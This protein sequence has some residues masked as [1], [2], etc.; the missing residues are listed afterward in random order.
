MKDEKAVAPEQSGKPKRRARWTRVKGETG[1]YKREDG[2]YYI[3]FCYNNAWC[4]EAAGKDLSTARALL[5]HKRN[6]ALLDKHG[7]KDNNYSVKKLYK[8]YLAYCEQHLKANTVQCY[9][10]SMDTVWKTLKC[11]RVS[12]IRPEFV[13]EYIKHRRGTDGVADATVRREVLLLKAML[14]FGERQGII[15]YNP[16]KGL[17][18]V[19]I[20]RRAPKHILTMEEFDR[21]V[22]HVHPNGSRAGRCSSNR[23]CRNSDIWLMLGL[24]GLRKSELANLRWS[25]VD[26]DRAEINI[27]EHEDDEGPKTAASNRTIPVVERVRLMLLRRSA[28]GTDGRV[29]TT[30]SGGSVA[31]NLLGKLHRCLDAAGID[32]TGISL[33]ALRRTFCS[34]LISRGAP[35]KAVQELMGHKD[36]RITLGVYAKTLDGD[37][38]RAVDVLDQRQSPQA[39][40]H[41]ETVTHDSTASKP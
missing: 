3:K 35:L 26:L 31:D 11:E 21:L 32:R 12:D 36:P 24:C 15:G 5:H 8:A 34:W 7:L 39:V 17:A 20:R 38:R 18:T 22:T 33:H 14:T 27:R 10:E 28:N 29:F 6:R 37:K 1:L 30:A 2:G 4:R 16:L 13:T 19:K 23:A 40:N 41:P 25:D 9:R